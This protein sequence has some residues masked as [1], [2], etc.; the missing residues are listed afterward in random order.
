MRRRRP[1]VSF[2]VRSIGLRVVWSFSVGRRIARPIVLLSIILLLIAGRLH[3]PIRI[4][5]RRRSVLCVLRRRCHRPCRGC[6]AHS[7]L[8]L[9]LLNLADLRNRHRAATVFLNSRLLPLESCGR[10]R[11][12]SLGDDRA[13]DHPLGRSGAGRAACP[14][15]SL[16]GRRRSRRR[17][18]NLC[19]GYLALIYPYDVVVHCLSAGEGLPGGRGDRSGSGFIHVPD[20]RDVF[21][22]HYSVVVVVDDGRVHRSIRDVHVVHVGATHV[23]RRHVDFTRSQREPPHSPATSSHAHSKA[24]SA[25][26][27]N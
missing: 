24:A 26:P 21:V 5:R 1:V 22:D 14:Q 25:N 2:V 3:R 19:I 4:L 27:G 13:G 8:R 17:N 18:G 10:R 12:S 15:N 23:I 16:L 20:V 6:H 9:L 7:W 11:R